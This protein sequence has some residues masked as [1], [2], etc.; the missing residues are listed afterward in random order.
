MAK[1]FSF[2]I[3][4]FIFMQLDDYLYF[5]SLFRILFYTFNFSKHLECIWCEVGL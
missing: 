3:P 4:F 1:V 2:M 5:Y